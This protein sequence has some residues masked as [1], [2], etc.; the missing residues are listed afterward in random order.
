[1]LF[2]I[3]LNS[4]A[5][6]QKD[7]RM[8][9]QKVDTLVTIPYCAVSA[10]YT[11]PSGEMGRRYKPF[12]DLGVDIGWKN[13]Q[14]WIFSFNFG[15][16][17]AANNVKIMN[18]ILSQMMTEGTPSFVVSGQGTDAG[19]V[20]SNRNLNMKFMFGKV[21]PLWFS[22]VNSGLMITIGGGWLQHQIL[23]QATHEIAYQLEGDRQYLYDRQ[24]RGPML[25]GFIGYLFFGK[26]SFANFYAGIQLDQAWTKMTR[27]YQADLRSGD[28]KRYSDRMLT[29]KAAWIF[30]FRNPTS[31]RIYY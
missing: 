2:V 21:I 18:D 23:F 1:M 30:Q 8:I 26:Y 10:G 11:I 28:T 15:F 24:M 31:E 4:I 3:F 5:E 6:A 17:F 20:A 14:N 7:D 25:S 27:I 29:F 13:K 16:Q 19:V 9:V 12:M 22:N